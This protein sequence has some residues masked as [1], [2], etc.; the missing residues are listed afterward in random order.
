MKK[1]SLSIISILLVVSLVAPQG[2]LGKPGKK[3]S[4]G[5][6]LSTAPVRKPAKNN[7]RTVK[8]SFEKV[9]KSRSSEGIQSSGGNNYNNSNSNV[10]YNRSNRVNSNR[11]KKKE[12]KNKGKLSIIFSGDMHSHLNAIHGMGGFAKIKTKIDDIKESYPD[13]F[14]L[15]AGDFSMGTAFQTVFMSDAAE[16][17]MLGYMDYDVA[18]LG[19]HEFDYRAKG[20]ARMLNRASD[21]KHVVTTSK[22]VFDKA[23]GMKRTE[24]TENQYM[25]ELVASNI[26]WEAT[27]KDK[28][29]AGNA[30]KLKRAMSKYGVADYTIV[31]KGDAKVAVFGLMGEEAVV[32]TPQSGVKWTNYIERA[33]KIVEEI[34]RNGEAD[35]II[36]LSHSGYY[37]EQGN[38][39]EDIK[40]ARKVPDIDVIISGHSHEKLDKPIKE[41]KTIIAGC[42]AYTEFLGH[43][44]L[45]ISK[46]GLSLDSYKLHKMDKDIKEDSGTTSEINFFKKRIDSRYFSKFGY[47]MDQTLAR[48]SFDFES[49]E[50]FI[51]NHGDSNLGDIIADSYRYGVKKA[52]GEDYEEI[53]CTVVPSGVVRGTFE[54]GKITVSDAFNVSSLGI[55]PDEIPGYPLV[56]VYL[57]GK[58]L[59]TLVE[60]DA[61][62]SPKMP[63][64]ILHMSGIKYKTNKHRLILNRATDIMKV[65]EDG[66]EEELKN[67]KLYR[68]V[69]GLYS[70][71]MLGAVTEKSKGLLSIVPKDKSGKE[72]TDFEKHIIKRRG[73]ELKEWY[74]LA[75]YIDS[76]K[77]GKVPMVYAKGQGRKTVNNSFAPWELVKQ[78]NNYG[79]IVLA[80]SLI[81]IVIIVGII[82]F[83]RRRRHSRRGFNTSM[84]GA[85]R[86]KRRPILKSNRMGLKRK[87]RKF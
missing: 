7:N 2:T 59:K 34:K 78:P 81:P 83:L 1:F 30:K 3:H 5:G 12:N 71:Q 10:Y 37:K 74:A 67:N 51:G 56:S 6:T 28:K 11:K 31:E 38:D 16:L 13:S 82:L 69:G 65:G 24:V 43:L 80:L 46:Q 75:S 55:G 48:S 63:N 61:S 27:L 32:D 14:L 22:V 52:E 36:C 29:L 73:K 49:M 40:L 9:K 45:D 26:D 72:I 21:S 15:D 86:K 57:T 18:T 8:K 66:K 42:G 76:F 50:S 64:A 68:V 17:R 62:I 60:V 54:K 58:E 79:V 47:S 20:L 41:G 23:T 35:Y 44:V 33:K 87:N 70:C 4:G 39:S 85:K 77:G 25:P 53:A 84:F 19:N